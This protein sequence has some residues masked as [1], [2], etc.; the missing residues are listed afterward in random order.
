M[1]TDASGSVLTVSYGN[2]DKRM[3]NP[4]SEVVPD[5][6]KPTYFPFR[7]LPLEL[8]IEVYKLLFRRAMCSALRTTG[9]SRRKLGSTK[10]RFGDRNAISILQTCR[11]F[12]SEAK[13]MFRQQVIVAFTATGLAMASALLA[14]TVL[15][16]MELSHIALIGSQIGPSV[17]SSVRLVCPQLEAVHLLLHDARC[18]FPAPL[19]TLIDSRDSDLDAMTQNATKLK[20]V[21]RYDWLQAATWPSS[22][23]LCPRRTTLV[24]ESCSAVLSSSRS[25]PDM[26]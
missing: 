1:H 3:A 11:L 12:R 15:D 13:S 23:P 4:G 5:G 24:R 21:F 17:L 9:K 26:T 20:D 6:P 18:G 22:P 16:T 10:K 25:S 14:S 19:R 8:R 7:G 2:A